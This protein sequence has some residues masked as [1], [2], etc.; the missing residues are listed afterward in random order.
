MLGYGSLKT[1]VPLTSMKMC[2][3]NMCT[4]YSSFLLISATCRNLTIT[5]DR[6]GGGAQAITLELYNSIT[7]PGGLG[8]LCSKIAYCY[9]PQFL[10]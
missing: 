7:S 8:E 9:I 6:E 3:V 5:L 1:P 10:R 4:G 2:L